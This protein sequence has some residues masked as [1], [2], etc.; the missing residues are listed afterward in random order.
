MIPDLEEH[1]AA[2]RAAM[3]A[4]T[5]TAA[6]HEEI[7]AAGEALVR[8]LLTMNE[9]PAEPVHDEKPSDAA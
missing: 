5:E 2:A 1:V 8:F 3:K 6:P 7:Y 9:P 4:A